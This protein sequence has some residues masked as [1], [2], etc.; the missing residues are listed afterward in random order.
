MLRR[1]LEADLGSFA[2][3][4]GEASKVEAGDGWRW[5]SGQAGQ[6]AREG[7]IRHSPEGWAAGQDRPAAG[8]PG[9]GPRY[10]GIPQSWTLRP[11]VLLRHGLADR[12]RLLLLL[13]G[14]PTRAME[15][16]SLTPRTHRHGKRGLQH[17]SACGLLLQAS[18]GSALLCRASAGPFHGLSVCRVSGTS[19]QS[20]AAC[21]GAVGVGSSRFEVQL[22]WHLLGPAQPRPCRPTRPGRTD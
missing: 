11:A 5:L 18:Q 4:S 17:A 22:T 8:A 1:C 10:L 2:P 9:S 14:F 19:C 20:R 16:W 13:A 15:V 3:D 7:K 6:E 12:R 21:A